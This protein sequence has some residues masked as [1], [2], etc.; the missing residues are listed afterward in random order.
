[1]NTLLF[2][3]VLYIIF[4]VGV[5]LR[6]IWDTRSVSKTLAYLLL[7]IFVPVVGVIFY[8]SFGINYRKHKMYSK[9]WK[10]TTNFR[11][12]SHRK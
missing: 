1:M 2:F 6:V 8:F 7:V 9:N 11:R 10:S 4:I 5:C 3:Q 12:N